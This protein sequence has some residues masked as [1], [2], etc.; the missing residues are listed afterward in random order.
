MRI[1]R[2][3]GAVVLCALIAAFAAAIVPSANAQFFHGASIQKNPV[4]P[5][6]AAKAHVGDTI[7]A[8]IRVRNV[9]D[10]E[11]SLTITS[12]LDVVHH[13]IGDQTSPNLLPAPVN[14]AN[15]GD[16]VTV[17]N[18]YLVLPGDPDV[19]QDD[20]L[21][22]GIDNHDGVN[23]TFLAQDFFI[24]FPGQI[25]V[26]RPCVQVSKSCVNGVGEN[27]TITWSG[28]ITNC[29]NTPLL[30]VTVSNL[31]NGQLVLVFGPTTLNTNASATFSGSYPGNCTPV[32]DTLLARGTDELGLTVTSSAT[33]TC[34]NIVTAGITITKN[35][36]QQIPT[37]GGGVLIG[38][39]PGGLLFF[40]GIVS[41]TGNVTL[42]NVVI[43]D[44]Q[45]A[46]NTPVAG[47]FSL[48][49]GAIFQYSGF[50]T[51]KVDNC[52]PAVDTV[53][54]T[55]RSVCGANVS[56][57]ATAS[58]PITTTPG[59]A[60]VKICP[61]SP[62]APGGVLTF[63]GYVTNTGNISL[64]NVVVVNDK[65]TPGTA[66]FGP[67]NLA[68]GAVL[69]FS[70]SY[71]VPNDS[72]GPYI[73]TLTVT[74]RSICGVAVGNT[75]TA[76]CASAINSGIVVTRN[77]P[78]TPTPSGTLLTFS[79]TV[80]NT[81]NVT[82]SNVVVV[83]DQP[84][85]NTPVFTVATLAPGQS[86]PFTSS[87]IVP[88]GA[89]GLSTETLIATA[90]NICG[91]IVSN[92]VTQSCPVFTYASLGDF[93]WHDINA[94]GI[95]EPGEPG[96]ANVSVFILSN[97][98]VQGSQ[99][100][101]ADGS[102]LFTGLIPGTYSVLFSNLP[103][104][105]VFSPADQGVNDGLDS[106]ANVA[107]GRAGPVTLGCGEV[108]RT[109]DAG[110]YKPACLGDYVWEDIN[111]DGIQND[112]NT[113]LSNVTVQLFA[114]GGSNVLQS[115]VTSSNGFYLFCGLVPGS[116]QVRVL[117]PGGYQVTL[118]NATND[119][120]DSDADATGLTGCT[121]LASGETN[122]C[123]D[124][125][126]Y[127]PAAIGDFVWR[128]LNANGLQDIGEPGV[129]NSVV[130]LQTC[131]GVLLATTNTDGNGRY[132]F[133]NL[134]PGSYK[135]TFL[136]PAGGG[137]TTPNLLPD[138]RDSDADTITGMTA[139]YTLVSGQTNLTVDA[140]FT[141]CT[142]TTATT[143]SSQVVCITQPVTFTTI[144]SGTGPFRYQWTFNGTPIEG[145]ISN[146]YSIP[147]ASTNNA[148]TYCVIVFGE[149]GGVTNC[150]TLQVLVP[151]I[152]V[153]KFCP[154]IPVAPGGLLTFSGSVANNGTVA[155]TNV[156]VVNNQPT[157]G[158]I[159]FGPTNLAVGQTLFFSGSYTTPAN[160]CG[161]WIDT[162]TSTARSTCGI[163]VTN[164]ATAQCASVVTPGIVVT[165]ACVGAT[166]PGEVLIFTGS[167]SNSGNIALTNVIVLNNQ[168]SPGTQVF[169]PTNLAPGQIIR[170]TNSYRIA[171]NFCGPAVDTL[172]AIGTSVCGQTVSNN[173]TASCPVITKP[174]LKMVKY[175]PP[176]PVAP[177]GLLT[178]TGAITNIGN[179][180]ITNIIIVND[181]PQAGT[182]VAGPFTLVPGEV[183]FFTNSY[184]VPFDQCGPWVDTLTATGTSICGTF[185]IDATSATCPAVT[186]PQIL[187]G[188][189]CPE[190]GTPPG[191]LLNFSGVVSNVGN[192]T[193]TNVIVV[194]NQPVAGTLVF[195]PVNLAPGEARF[196]NGSYTTPTNSCGP[197]IDTLTATARSICGQQVTN[198]AT[199]QCASV[200]APAII[201]TK[202]CAGATGPGEVL[203]FTGSVSNSGNITLTNVIVLNDQPSPGTQVFGPTNL[204]PGQIVRFTNSYRVSLN[205]C[206]P[207]VDT[208]TAIGTSVCGQSVTNTAT[209]LCPVITKPV[210]KM[211]KNCPPTPVAPGGLL[212][213][214]G[215]ITN[216]GNIDITNIIIVNDKP[217]AG[218]I[219]DGPFNLAIGQVRFFT[220]SYRVPFDQCGPW[221]DTL[222]ATGTSICGTFAIDATSATCPALIT[223]Q[224]L[225]AKFCPEGATAPG[226][227]LTFSGVVSNVGNITLTNV[228]VVNNQP[229]AGTIVFGP[230][231]LAPGEARFFTG[232]YIT[233]T[234]S[235]GPWVDTLTATARSICG[236]QVTHSA[237]A[238]CPVVVNP[239]V[240]VNKFCPAAPT[241]PG[242]FIVYVGSV[243]NCGNVGLTNV[244][245]TNDR[246][247]GVNIFGPT[248]LAPGQVYF[249]TNS[250]RAPIDSCGPVFDNL[251]VSGSTLCG[252]PV[253]NY[254]DSACPLITTPGL[255]VT[256]SCPPTAVVPGSVLTFTGSVSN[257]GNISLTN[258]IVVNNQPTPNTV[259]FGPV[260]LAPGQVRF[261]T[262]SYTTSPNQCGPWVD[263]L[264]ARAVSICGVGITNS[265]TAI[266]A[267]T[268]TPA[269]RVTK[270]CPSTPTGP[271]ELLVFSGTVSNAGNIILTNVTVVNNQPQANTLVFGPVT[272]LP[273]EVRSFTGSYRTPF[274]S[275]GPY[276]DTL[277]ASARSI[278]G[279]TVS[280]SATAVCPGITTPRISITKSCP[281][282]NTPFFSLLV[283]SGVVSNSG[284]ITLTNVVV[285]D[286]KPAPNTLVLGPTNL[287]PGAFIRFTNSYFID[288]DCCGPYADM[289]TAMGRDKCTGSNV[290]K[291]ATAVCQALTLPALS[292]TRTCPTNQITLGV[293]IPF[294]GIV[295][296]SGTVVLSNVVVINNNGEVIMSMPG[297]S[298][299]EWMDYS[300]TFTITNCPISGQTT[301]VITITGYDICSG[302]QVSASAVCIITCG[303][304]KAPL[305]I[306]S[307][308]VTRKGFAVSF[309]TEVGYSYRIEY[310]DSL[311]A[312]VTWQPLSAFNGT[313]SPV[314][315]EDPA[316]HDKRFYRVVCGPPIIDN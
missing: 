85:P 20:A 62:T 22:G 53:T 279:V 113:G 315:Y 90:R 275:C 46:P 122:L 75:A 125:G 182:V 155:L 313:G 107:T 220:N 169:G 28:S 134:V 60:V 43:V 36:P 159:V 142:N 108:N 260:T 145:A 289:L 119:C 235:C 248:N 297:F 158:A 276:S 26:L 221:V 14:L 61:T 24:T 63:T 96:L 306:Q 34:S 189:F 13:T 38:T 312:P 56:A 9:D 72:C 59:I 241:A 4:G 173:A 89:C 126:L 219:V 277:T 49:P 181:K 64:T 257:S 245:V 200:T 69:S 131:A 250:Y 302:S 266:C 44:N 23:A 213:F 15:F 144:A 209:A 278:C 25:R 138:D 29:G 288:D 2:L 12:I 91:T 283:Y 261:F 17:T 101:A 148:G 263:T 271:N 86:L 234:N 39:P 67:T 177:G 202:Q 284:N 308:L 130:Q 102:Y 52:G 170:F 203:I 51:T 152:T 211:V 162:L 175:C 178:F 199:A 205:F 153:S 65:P 295:S 282:T 314:T 207:A 111:R 10:F 191:G 262:N 82:L 217:Q 166:S 7:T 251:L 267:A 233:P 280:N 197:W 225:V 16:F 264:T 244:L 240:V 161:P 103:A 265:A 110:A 215:A 300:G 76:Q 33:A 186:S 272:L 164:S 79:G 88:Q 78:A 163:A 171:L 174:V 183:T 50:Y 8:G 249:F 274:D 133:A 135:V 208:L 230:T 68:P 286:N 147:S 117:V 21:A 55:A 210:L 106:D 305:V 98:V 121:T 167:I 256:K 176:D 172:T 31:V 273:G 54:V 132:L 105:F 83:G 99:L 66:V 94:N 201:V 151:S 231:N 92:S 97:N 214:T 11:D 19:L 5:S 239:C 123:T 237:T 223:P 6:G 81:G 100:T 95:Q 112:G 298:V 242:G 222:T 1:I 18:T 127:R 238:T 104:G 287:A 139:C 71:T 165:K 269:I 206:G 216:I 196:F 204:A 149:C 188:K 193:L 247:I 146:S 243:S 87:Y 179:I 47:P 180:T 141:F 236:Q 184:R 224:I 290:V 259:V 58:C 316:T 150:A 194:N 232:S 285:F 212:T 116:Y 304:G 80:S 294:S 157:P 258:V 299:R 42:T 195:G 301:N 268:N 246:Q 143:P 154:E 137:F 198:S 187:V 35:C 120:V 77:C 41:N 156:V 227:L 84:V 310:T 124:I 192:I 74:A 73:D 190:I 253:T 291:T 168:P 292:I 93:V 185:A 40:S 255:R 281:L 70:G 160:S 30:N 37:D 309:Q 115:T 129:S 114:C 293:P 128:D 303:Q 45:P 109:V 311:T 307:P 270:T 136:A 48:A 218:T 226:G 3:R 228:V 57:N 32:T 254:V 27:G 229:V 296:N 140:G 118:Q 252:Q